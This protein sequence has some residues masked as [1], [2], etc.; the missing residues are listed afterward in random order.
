MLFEMKSSCSALIR[1]DVSR[2][3]EIS[4]TG[5]EESVSASISSPA[6]LKNSSALSLCIKA[7]VRDPL[8]LDAVSAGDASML[9]V[10]L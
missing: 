6:R 10:T 8:R 9:S 1:L 5:C 7:A 3:A 4:V 2:A